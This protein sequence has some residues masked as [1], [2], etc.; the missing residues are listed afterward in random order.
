MFSKKI[1]ALV[2]ILVLSVFIISCSDDNATGNVVSDDSEEDLDGKDSL[3]GDQEPIDG[4]DVNSGTIIDISE[5]N[6]TDEVNNTESDSDE[7][8][9]D[10]DETVSNDEG[11]SESPY[12]EPEHSSR[13]V[14][15]LENED[16]EFGK[17]K[18]MFEGDTHIIRIGEIRHELRLI[19]VVSDG[20]ML[21][22]F[23]GRPLDFMEYGEKISITRDYFVE[24]G[25]GL[26][27]QPWTQQ[28]SM[29]EITYVKEA[30]ES[31][32]DY[33]IEEDIGFQKYIYSSNRSEDTFVAHYSKG[34]E[35]EVET[36]FDFFDEYDDDENLYAF[37]GDDEY[38]YRIL[39]EYDNVEEIA[40]LSSFG[41]EEVVVRVNKKSDLIIE[42]Y[43]KKWPT[44]IELE[45][46]CTEEVK[47]VEFE[48]QT[49]T[50][51]DDDYEIELVQVIDD[52][53]E[54]KFRINGEF[55][56]RFELGEK[57]DIAPGIEIDI[58]DIWLDYIG[59]KDRIRFCFMYGE[60]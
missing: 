8:D 4:D 42:R 20:K 25:Y 54:V 37:D 45:D 26:Y 13:Y 11:D 32:P 2:L 43:L 35:V 21:F 49:F 24:V 22:E 9:G 17:L 59:D 18:T 46:Y 41:E 36:D 7:T 58:K 1:F 60:E 39:D 31:Y 56:P 47:M 34:L 14:I 5:G 38:V 33:L 3:S 6:A 53:Y 48:T 12:P 40:W 15:N 30:Y 28:S 29:G 27:N 44:I 52:T 16:F 57:N 50:V 51:L 23:D 10:A 55:Q 19:K